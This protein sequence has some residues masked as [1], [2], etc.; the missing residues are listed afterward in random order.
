MLEHIAGGEIFELI[1]DDQKHVGVTEILLRRMFSELAR[2]VAWMHSVALVHRDIKLES[3]Q[4]R[5]PMLLIYS[6]RLLDILLTCNPFASEYLDHTGSPSLDFLPTPLL[7]LT[8]FGLSRFVNPESPLL[9]TRCGSE[10]YAAPEIVMAIKYDGRQTDAWACGVV[11]FALATRVLPF[12]DIVNKTQTGGGS[13]GS[14]GL[15]SPSGS[16]SSSFS[17]K[18]RRSYLMRIAKN[19]YSWPDDETTARLASPALRRVVQRLLVRD[20]KKRSTMAELWDEDWMNGDGSMPRP[21][22]GY[23]ISLTDTN[24]PQDTQTSRQVAS[25]PTVDP[26]ADTFVDTIEDDEGEPDPD[27][28][29]LVDG[30]SI[31]HVA[32]SEIS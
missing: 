10:S 13:I 9:A 2:A 3:E 20:P 22:E 16:V 24:E 25:S 1:N 28:G 11:L 21:G 18:G 15:P 19:E 26:T 4:E 23:R 32:R 31:D 8:D 14:D 29:L 12:D 7:K 6:P 30:E 5:M 17:N 27:S